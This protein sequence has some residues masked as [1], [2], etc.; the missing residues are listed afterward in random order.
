M[1]AKDT[2][3][4]AP[5][6]YHLPYD[7]PQEDAFTE[8][9]MNNVGRISL[10]GVQP[11]FSLIMD[12]NGVLRYTKKHEQGTYMMKLAPTAYFRNLQDFA[13]NEHLTMSIASYVFSI[14]TAECAMGFFRDGHPAYITKRFDIS[15]D[16][17]K[18]AQEDLASVA[19]VTKATGG[20]DYKYANLSY[21]EC[22]QLI[23]H[24]V[25]AAPVE[26]LRFFQIILFN[27]LFLNNDAHLKN[28]SLINRG[29]EYR[30]APAY[31]LMNTSLHLSNY[32]NIFA[33][34]KGLFKEGMDLSDTRWI[35]RDEFIDFGK[36]MGLPE[37]LIIKNIEQ[38]TTQEEKVRW[39]SEHSF[40]SEK[41]KNT[42]WKDYHF[43]C[44]MLR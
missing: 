14:E 2:F 5:V 43:R 23:A 22:G 3:K 17:S 26:L 41:L 39:F 24:H 8:T 7:S 19:G 34:N 13:A 4:W 18:Y 9:A 40:L 11:K 12:E 20:D 30:L 1:K 6:V 31:D 38:M 44:S 32:N 36:R 25:K 35:T 15:P 10:S 33:L 28:F 42:Y 37:K 16:G 29:G 27:F 21:E